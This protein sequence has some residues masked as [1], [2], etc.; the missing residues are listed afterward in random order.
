MIGRVLSDRYRIDAIIASGSMGAVYRGYHVKTRKEVALKILHPETENFP[1]LVARFEREAV[2]GAHIEHPN[3][4]SASD[5]GNFDQGSYFLVLEYVRGR[6]LRELLDREAPLRPS[7]A[8]ALARQ[9]A[10]GL[11]AA[12]ARGI[13]HRDLKPLNV[14]VTNGPNEQVKIID[15]GL[16]RISVDH[17]APMEGEAESA[18]VSQPGV[19]F[20]TVAYMAPEVTGG[21]DAVDRPSDLYALGLILYEMLTAMHPF[22]HGAFHE[23]IAQHRDKPPPS[24]RERNRAVAV[25]PAIEAIVMRLLEKDPAQR[26]ADVD[27]LIEALDAVAPGLDEASSPRAF[28]SRAA[29][30]APQVRRSQ[31]MVVVGGALALA[32]VILVVALVRSGAEEK[33]AASA[34]EPAPSASEAP[35]QE[36]PKKDLAAEL[37]ADLVRVAAS[38]GDPEAASILVALADADPKALGDA[39]LRSAATTVAIAVGDGGG[40]EATQ[41]FYVLAYRFGAEGLDVLYDVSTKSDHPR[42]ARRAGAILEVQV[43]TGRPSAALRIALEIKKAPCKQKPLL[44]SRAASEGD[45]RVLALLEELRPPACDP[46]GGACCFRRHIGLEKTIDALKERASLPPHQR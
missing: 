39:S 38:P 4:A 10:A 26:Y 18:R 12:H 37:R 13:V 16:A 23:V 7:R 42:A 36:P 32:V 44:F 40:D 25:P 9:I 3:V 30:A 27:A 19:V 20:G 2:A 11:G 46:D 17:V 15:F 8:L 6:T 14:M 31:A 33:T 28:T 1:D 35:P 21:M 29:A 34:A 45:A 41:A 43:R 5:M 24:L 22:E